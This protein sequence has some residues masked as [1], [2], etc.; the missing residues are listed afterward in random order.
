MVELVDVT[1]AGMDPRRLAKVVD[2]F[3]RQQASGVFPGGQLVVRRR[4]VLAVDEAVG[5]ARGFRDSE[6]ELQRAFTPEQRSCVFSAGK[7][8]VAV[9]VALLE[10][11]GAI[12]VQRPV[13]AYWP[14]FARGDKSA[15]TLLDVL[16]HRSGLYLRDIEADWRAFA[17]WERVVSRI[18]AHTPSF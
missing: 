15:I 6:G 3:R 14:E 11:R 8:L 2:T 10:Q 5:I 1:R 12:D 16:L 4:G 13:A 9:A 17:D 7:P 18:A